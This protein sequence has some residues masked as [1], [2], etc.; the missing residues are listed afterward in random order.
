MATPHGEEE[1]G[2]ER[3]AQRQC[4]MHCFCHEDC[5]GR[6]GESLCKW[7][8]NRRKTPCPPAAVLKEERRKK[9]AT[10]KK[11]DRLPNEREAEGGRAGHR[12]L[13]CLAIAPFSPGQEGIRSL[14]MRL[15]RTEEKD[16]EMNLARSSNVSSLDDA[17]APTPC[18]ITLHP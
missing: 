9:W 1:G 3:F 18:F 4:T 6:R 12:I 16:G 8:P 15:L 10:S 5:R 14:P 2:F 13:M 17:A 7:V 11:K